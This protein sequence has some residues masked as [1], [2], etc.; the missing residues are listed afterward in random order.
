[1]IVEVIA[2]LIEVK[3]PEVEVITV[4]KI[5]MIIKKKTKISRMEMKM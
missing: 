1:V 3:N 2:V 5:E 4:N